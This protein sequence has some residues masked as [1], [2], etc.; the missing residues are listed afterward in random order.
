MP[1]SSTSTS[2]TYL[3]RSAVDAHAQRLALRGRRAHRRRAL[4]EL[5]A[6]AVGPRRSARGGTSRCSRRP[7]CVSCRRSSRT[8][9]GASS[10][11]RREPRPSAALQPAR[12]AADD[13]D[14][15]L[16]DDLDLA[17]R[18]GDGVHAKA[19]RRPAGA[20][21]S[22]TAKTGAGR[23]STRTVAPGR[24]AARPRPTSGPRPRRRPAGWTWT[25]HSEPRKLT[26]ST[27]RPR[28]S[29]G[30]AHRLRAD[31][32]GRPAGPRGAPRAAGWRPEDLDDAVRRGP[33]TR[34]VRP[35]NSATN[36]SRPVVQLRRWRDLLEPPGR[37]DA[38][39]V[40]HRERLLLVVGHEEGRVPTAIWIRRISSR[41]W[42]RTLASSA[43]SGSSSRSTLGSIASA[44]AS[45][46]RCCWP[47][48]S[49]YG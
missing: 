47:P 12:S 43:D 31:E 48:D 15:G 26:A 32:R 39:P 21:H 7:T 38:D 11:R 6:D 18:F 1:A 19:L 27:G 29:A 36:R 4:L 22:A 49:W 23:T 25:R 37:H 42:R 9:R 14:L 3:K 17:R 41:S 16:V 13:E 28:A 35:T 20:V 30:E 2:A 5:A 8:G 10:R 46:T 24:E 33:R 40:A 34:F 45:A 44:R